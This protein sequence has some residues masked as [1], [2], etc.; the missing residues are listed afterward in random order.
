MSLSAG[1]DFIR[2]LTA[3]T[4]AGDDTE[5]KKWREASLLKIDD[6]LPY[7]PGAG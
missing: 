7:K 2:G 5:C 6:L 1:V 3:N 4:G